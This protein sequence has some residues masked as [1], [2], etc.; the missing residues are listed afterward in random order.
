MQTLILLMRMLLAIHASAPSTNAALD[1][2][3]AA[4]AVVDSDNPVFGSAEMDLAVLIETAWRESRFQ[5]DAVGDSG[6][7]LGVWQLQHVPRAVAF[8]LALS[9]PIAYAR[10]REAAS[11][12]PGAP[13]APYVGGCWSPRARLE[14]E[15]RLRAARKLAEV[16][17]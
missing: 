6:D 7:S 1:V 5:V 13:L 4:N 3:L 11:Q 2:A 12:C 16:V 8:D 15:R 14:G 17:R 9:T 10:L